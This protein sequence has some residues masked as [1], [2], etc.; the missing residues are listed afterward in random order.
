MMINVRNIDSSP[1][2]VLFLCSMNSVINLP[3]PLIVIVLPLCKIN[4][5]VYDS[6]SFKSAP[7]AR[8][9]KQNPEPFQFPRIK[10]RS[11]QRG[12]K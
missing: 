9:S 8:K 1:D 4:P 5:K 12:A 3:R 6:I 2:A 10:A 11:Q 7:V